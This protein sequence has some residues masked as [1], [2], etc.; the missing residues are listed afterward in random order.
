MNSPYEEVQLIYRNKTKAAD[1]PIVN[2]AYAA[3]SI[4]R[5]SWNEAQIQLFEESRMLLLDRR[6]KLMSIA[7]LSQG[8]INATTI[9][10]RIIFMI[11][12]K[13]RAHRI[14]L[15][16]NHTCDSAQPSPE[17]IGITKRIAFLGNQLRIPLEDHIILTSDSYCSMLNEGY[18]EPDP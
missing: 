11:A 9:D 15:A 6:M 7:K 4:L 8:G 16:H 5:K 1:R 2:T 14:I 17:D 18:M 12:L 3:H 10:P 13:R